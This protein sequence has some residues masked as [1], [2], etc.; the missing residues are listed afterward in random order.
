MSLAVEVASLCA[1]LPVGPVE[2]SVVDVLDDPARPTSARLSA[3]FLDDLTLVYEKSVLLPNS[4]LDFGLGGDSST[5]GLESLS[6]LAS[7]LDTHL[8]VTI[9][10]DLST[11]SCD[12]MRHTLVAPVSA[13]VTNAGAGVRVRVL[14]LPAAWS[15]A[16]HMTTRFMD[17]AGIRL[18]PPPE[19]VRVGFNHSRAPVGRVF[20]AATNNDVP[21]LVAALIAG[22]STEEAD[23][24]GS[25]YR[26]CR[27]RNR[28]PCISPF[29]SPQTDWTPLIDAARLGHLESVRV[30]VAAGASLNSRSGVRRMH[31]FRE[32]CGFVL[33]LIF[34]IIYCCNSFYLARQLGYTPLHYAAKNGHAEVVAFLL[35][36][37]GVTASILDNVSD[38]LVEAG[39]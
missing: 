26:R 20:M 28:F 5:M 24:V 4:P 30:L 7:C 31:G 32:S 23:N 35:A 6:A 39:I 11:T 1:F 25:G 29:S 15:E 19:S 37:P 3:P 22:F 36:T 13:R 14:A 2:I 21:A 18:L 8:R 12:A 17:L 34:S 9:H 33:L 38:C 27:V 16:T 10:P